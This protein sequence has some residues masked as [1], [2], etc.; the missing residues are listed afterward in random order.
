MG[1]RTVRL[2]SDS[3]LCSN[4]CALFI[5]GS[6]T[7]FILPFFD[8]IFSAMPE[9]TLED[10]RRV[11]MINSLFPS[12]TWEWKKVCYDESANSY[13]SV[14]RSV[15]SLKSYWNLHHHLWEK[16]H[17]MVDPPLSIP[18]VYISC[19]C[20]L[21]HADFRSGLPRSPKTTE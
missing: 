20:Q 4:C 16:P 2:H 17:I 21:K 13:G 10:L 3:P 18:N 9:F 14:H 12:S 7:I 11:Y 6:F 5:L 15:P 8:T 1:R 19:L